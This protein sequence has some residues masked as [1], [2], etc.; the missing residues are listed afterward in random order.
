MLCS[1][2]YVGA[3]MHSEFG[4]GKCD[5]CRLNRS[6]LW[7]GRLLL[8]STQH[9]SSI[10]VTLTYNDENVP[11]DL[12]P[13]HLRNFL[14]RLRKRAQFPVRYYAVGEYGTRSLRPHYHL[15]LF[16]DFVTY[17]GTALFLRCDVVDDSWTL[18]H[19]HIGEFNSQTA[20]YICKYTTKFLS[21]V[22]DPALKGKHPEFARMSTRPG[23][24]ATALPH[25]ADRLFTRPG[26]ALVA[27]QGDVQTEFMIDGH[28]F[29]LGRYLTGRLRDSMGRSPG[30][31]SALSLHRSALRF[32]ED[33][34]NRESV[35]KQHAVIARRRVSTQL[36]K[37]K[38]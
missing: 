26:C 1:T 5:A 37:E 16:G 25:L 30:V 28:R 34:S 18:G 27:V 11:T 7:Q 12:R 38:I 23:I 35:R 17:R 4:C 10:F 32:S 9:A 19:V 8:E 14:K 29:L 13:E 6:R 24:G 3:G 21:R 22:G 31:P 36:S 20:S 33:R 2:P 15:V